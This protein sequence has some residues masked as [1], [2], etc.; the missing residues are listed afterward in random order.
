MSMVTADFYIAGYNGFT[1][2]L[3]VLAALILGVYLWGNS[4]H[5]K[6]GKA[7]KLQHTYRTLSRE[8]LDKIPDE[9]LVDA[10]AAN[11]LAKL[12]EQNPDAYK[13][14]TALSRGRCAVYSIWVICHELNSEGL[15]AYLKSPSGRFLELTV[16]GFQTVGA[17]DC[18]ALLKEVTDIRSFDEKDLISLQEKMLDAVGREQPLALCR[19]YIRTNPDEFIDIFPSSDNPDSKP[20]GLDEE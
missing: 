19:D 4:L 6:E 2:A 9:D 5:K 7:E 12:D 14:I 13:T 11:L 15:S 20:S 17:D 8:I 18:A 1:F 3:L 16:T 10:V